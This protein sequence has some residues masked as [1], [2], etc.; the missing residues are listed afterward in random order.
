MIILKL[1]E[2]LSLS[3]LLDYSQMIQREIN[4]AKRQGRREIIITDESVKVFST[5]GELK[6]VKPD[7][8][9]NEIRMDFSIK[10]YRRRELSFKP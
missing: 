3:Q 1:P 10:R 6:V 2:K 7:M 5:D 9:T 8:D 4:E